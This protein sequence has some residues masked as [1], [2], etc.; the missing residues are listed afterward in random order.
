MHA[1]TH[2]NTTELFSIGAGKKNKQMKTEA[3]EMLEKGHT[4]LLYGF[5]CKEEQAAIRF[6]K[7]ICVLF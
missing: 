7:K 2:T 1:H 4:I 3:K 5:E 6:I